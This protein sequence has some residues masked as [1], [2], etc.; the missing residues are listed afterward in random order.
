MQ[1][2]L[3]QDPVTIPQLKAKADTCTAC[4]L[5]QG[6]KQAVFSSGPHNASIMIVGEA[7]GENEDNDGIP[8]VG[9][10][11]QLLNKALAAVGIPRTICYVTNTCKH[12]PTNNRTP[13][14]SEANICSTLFLTREISVVK[15]K[16]IIALGNPA[17]KYFLG[18]DKAISTTRGNWYD[19]AGI[20]LIPIFHPAFI[21]RNPERSPGSPAD[22]FWKD[23]Q[24]VKAKLE[25]LKVPL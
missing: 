2:E 23:L 3:I 13:T 17:M 14:P 9:K 5:Y 7:P 15:P 10:A 25:E 11:G 24:A 19:H 8:F 1:L 21:L 4:T 20:A 22:L 18:Q 6:T 12:R 16:V